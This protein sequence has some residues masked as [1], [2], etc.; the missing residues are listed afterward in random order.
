M[1]VLVGFVFGLCLTDVGFCW[2]VDFVDFVVL[3]LILIILVSCFLLFVLVIDLFFYWWN[4]PRLL[5]GCKGLLIGLGL[6]DLCCYLIVLLALFVLG[7]LLICFG[8]PGLVC[9]FELVLL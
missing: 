3:C 8:L 1:R 7:D 4:C 9:V 2:L 6:I 5:C